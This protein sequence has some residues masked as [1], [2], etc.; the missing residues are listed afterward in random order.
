MRRFEAKKEEKMRKYTGFL[1]LLYVGKR[2]L[3]S[4]QNSAFIQSPSGPTEREREAH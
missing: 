3:E 4:Y 1:F 2:E